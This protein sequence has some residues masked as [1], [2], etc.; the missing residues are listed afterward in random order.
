[1][2]QAMNIK[3]NGRDMSFTGNNLAE[4]ID[5]LGL[6]RAKVVAEKNGEAVHREDAAST[7]LVEGDVVELVRLVGGG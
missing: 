4:L 1:M 3:V 2:E 6:D 7:P 5:R